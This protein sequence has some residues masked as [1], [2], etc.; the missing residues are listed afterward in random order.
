MEIKRKLYL[1]TNYI[2]NVTK[3][4]KKRKKKSE[5]MMDQYLRSTSCQFLIRKFHG[6]H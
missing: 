4:K 3:K 6:L 1:A 2:V 5:T